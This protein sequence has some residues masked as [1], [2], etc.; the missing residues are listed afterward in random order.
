MSIA[1]MGA[2]KESTE[3]KLEEALQVVR[4]TPPPQPRVEVKK[5]RSVRRHMHHIDTPEDIFV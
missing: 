2:I 3:K 5:Q 4:E 1:F